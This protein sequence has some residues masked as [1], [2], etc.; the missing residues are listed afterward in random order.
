VPMSAVVTLI[1]AALAVVTQ[2]L[3]GVVWA[4]LMFFTFDN[5]IVFTFGSLLPLGFTDGS[6]L[7]HYWGKQKDI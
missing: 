7:L 2:P 1:G 5:L 6:T 3:G 4:V